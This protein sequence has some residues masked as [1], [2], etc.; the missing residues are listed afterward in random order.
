M[1]PRDVVKRTI[2]FAKPER[3]PRCFPESYGNDVAGVSMSPNPDGRPYGKRGVET[4]EWGAVWENIGVCGLGEV[5]DFPV[6]S[7]SDFD[8]IKIPDV[9]EERR[10][11]SVKGARARAGDKFLIASGISLYER[12]HFLRGLENLWTDI[13]EEPARLEKLL[14]ILADMNVAA[15][16]LYKAEEPDGYMFCDDWGLQD[17]LMI[18]P[19]SWRELWK[20][21]YKRI[22]DA[23]HKAGMRTLLHSCGYIVEILDDL[24]DAGLDVIQ[25]DQQENMG[26]DLLS[27]RFAGRICFWC[28]VD[29]QKTMCCG[30][31]D[32]IRRYC[33][34]LQEKLG[35]PEGGFIPKWYNDQ[36]GAGH[37]QEAVD[38]MCSEFLKVSKAKFGA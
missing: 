19:S 36:K 22:F 37:A 12:S 13:Y 27:E 25:M 18:S 11:L 28:P 2:D 33:W 9:T 35:K 32:S 15:I 38:A 24:I 16:E 26:L 23:A 1:T 8:K 17:K 29:I 30:D 20:P 7:W 31:M 4:D 5:K 10:W 6:K 14:D 21:R 3:L 34:L